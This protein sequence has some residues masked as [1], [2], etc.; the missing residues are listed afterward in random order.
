MFCLEI[1]GRSYVLTSKVEIKLTW[2]VVSTHLKNIS[3]IGLF[4]QVGL[5]IK[6][7]WN[8]H[9]ITMSNTY[10]ST[11]Y[12]RIP[13]TCTFRTFNEFASTPVECKRSSK[14]LLLSRMHTMVPRKLPQKNAV[15]CPVVRLLN[16]KVRVLRELM[17]RRLQCHTCN[18]EVFCFGGW[19][20]ST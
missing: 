11:S 10:I 2:L 18:G 19:E 5:K 13:Y 6:N 3:P 1:L 12:T 20:R 4:P 14:I 8:H 9:R 17:P 7:I 15:K 16:A